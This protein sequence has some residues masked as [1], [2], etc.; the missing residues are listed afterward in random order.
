MEKRSG[1]VEGE[2]LIYE[3]DTTTLNVEQRS[4]ALM[5]RTDALLN[6]V[7][8]RPTVRETSWFRQ[9]LHTGPDGTPVADI[10]AAKA[11]LEDKLSVTPEVDSKL[12]GITFT[13]S[14]PSDCSTIINELV[15]EHLADQNSIQADVLRSRTQDLNLTK[16]SLTLKDNR[17][18]EDIAKLQGELNSK[19]IMT[20]PNRISERDLEMQ[21][22]GT[23]ESRARDEYSTAKAQ[24]D[25]LTDHLK[26]GEDPPEV[27]EK[28]P[29]T[30]DF[31]VC[32]AKSTS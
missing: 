8:S 11:D 19:G 20:G 3:L 18:K 1:R 28:S 31:K 13:Y 14:N 7:L 9:F 25:I 10:P 29:K 12:I 26:N 2:G 17:L 30:C 23:Q 22:L 16:S 21:A 15:D 4:Q 24:L 32:T 27:D 6:A 5:L